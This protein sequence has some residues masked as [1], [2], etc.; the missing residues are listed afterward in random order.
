LCC[1]LPADK[2]HRDCVSILP[3]DEDSVANHAFPD[4]ADFFV[5][6]DG[7]RVVDMDGKLDTDEACL[8]RSLQSCLEE[9][10]PE[11]P[12][13]KARDNPHAERSA[14]S[15]R[16]EVMPPNV[17]PPGHFALR[18]GDDMRVAPFEGVEHEF[19][20]LRQWR[21]FEKREIFPLARDRVERP[22]KAL[23]VFGRHWRYR[24]VG[25]RLH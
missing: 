13:A 4:K 9:P 18:Q 23:D 2:R 6:S 24:R 12:A 3:I 7:A 22:M 17:A 11:T 1:V 15:V 21:R 8:A 25:G 16:R 14:M 10:R 20:D 5:E 19:A